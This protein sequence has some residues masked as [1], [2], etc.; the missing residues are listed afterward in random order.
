MTTQSLRIDGQDTGAGKDTGVTRRQLLVRA[1][2]GGGFMVGCTLPG[3]GGRGMA[4][5]QSVTSSGVT[6]WI[7][8]GSDESITIAVPITEMGQGTMTGLA[9]I[10]ADEL[11]VAWSNIRVVHAPVDAAHGGTNASPWGRFTGG[12]LGIRLFS[13]GMQ[14]A[15]AN[16]RQML[17]MAAA[18]TWGVSPSA[19]TANLGAISANVGG[20]TKSLSYANLAPAAGAIVLGS[21][22]PLNLYPRT[23][24]GTSPPRVDLP[25][26]VNGSAQFGIDVMQAGMVFASVKHCP[27]LG[28]TV[29]AVGSKPSG[30][31]AVVPV[32]AVGTPGVPGYKPNNAVAVIATNTWDAMKGAKSVSVTW[33]PPA[34]T[35]STDSA[36]INARAAWLM[37]NGSAIVAQDSN[38]GSLAA[39]LA[40]PNMAINQTYQLPYLAHAAMEPMNC[41]SRFR[42]ATSSSPARCD[43]WAPTQAPDGVMQTAAALCP[44]GTAVTVVNTL[45]G[46]GFGRKFEM[47]FI[48]QSVQVALA[49]PTRPVKL[50]WPREQDFA[51][52]QF[53]P[54]ALSG[55]SAGASPSGKITAWRHRVVT[56]S[57]AFQRGASATALDGSAVDGAIQLPYAMGSVL[58]DYV[59]HDAT[60]PVGYWRSVGMSINTFAVESAMDELAAAIGWDPIQFRLSNLANARMT[61]VLTRLKTL[62]N[63]GTPGGSGRAQGVAIAEG[64]G[65]FVGQ[66]AEISVNATTGAI[67]VHRIS[68]VIDCGTAV[69]PD[70]I[71][72]QIE[73][74]VAQAVSATLYA[75][76]TFV[77]GVAQATN[78]S[79]YRLLRLRDMPQVDV[80]IIAD[81]H[82]PGGVGEPG[83]PCVAPA[84]ANAHARLVGSAARKRSLPF[85]PGSSGG[86]L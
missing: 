2:A 83:I 51:N 45:V 43:V 35:A 55:I 17:I 84:I 37:T 57:I 58:V 32:G 59:R 24:V 78:Y 64:F 60:V 61:N 75:Q 13:P 19:C 30:A 20:V 23:L 54:M 47:D 56:P 79:K 41:T 85:F 4:H 80:Q 39:G 1:A 27:T 48:R 49:Y 6:V 68:A 15:A 11:R 18:Q 14:Q 74:A 16:A 42:P 38:S 26:K 63:W 69:N 76:Q 81:G 34:E 7:T 67:T 77:K 8:V 50:T 3:V 65:S 5:A 22:T 73:G 21:N 36:S 70:A 28:G 52:D 72:A 25:A 10:V 53:R 71:K 82:A 44:A 9:Q 12:S 62:S 29:G 31:L 46:A 86:G 33:T 66:V 40:A